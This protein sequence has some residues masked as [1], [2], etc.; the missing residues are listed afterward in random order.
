MRSATTR[1]LWAAVIYIFAVWLLTTGVT[2]QPKEPPTLPAG[3]DL[4]SVLDLGD[5]YVKPVPTEKDPRTGFIVGGKND[6]T[7]IRGLKAING[8]T[9]AELEK[10][11]RPGAK[12][13][14]GS[15]A[16][17]IGQDEKLLDVL[18]EDN[19]YVVESLGLT[20]QE[21][22]KHLHAMGTIGL[23]QLAHSKGETEFV[24]HAGKFKVK[25]EI[26]KGFQLSPFLD[27]TKTNADAT[28]HNLENGK[29]LQYSLLVPH[30]IERYGFY[31]GKGT[32][33]RVDPR[34]IVEVFGFLKTKA[35]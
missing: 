25:V 23:W 12:S 5:F 11:M 17:F 28:I 13:D 32:P 6:T 35:K 27:G 30:M 20:H 9:I 14:V 33:Y 8:R 2:A 15:D 4:A 7:V 16:G 26:S 18:A 34:Q 19:R 3:L 29:K 24:Y 31:E 21:L 22:A 1:S 10:D